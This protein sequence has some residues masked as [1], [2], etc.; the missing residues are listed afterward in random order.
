MT[1][2]CLLIVCLGWFGV[3]QAQ[4]SNDPEL[5]VRNRGSMFGYIKTY[6]PD[7]EL[8]GDYLYFKELQPVTLHL[9]DGNGT[10]QI[11]KA[12]LDLYNK[13]LLVDIKDNMY[14]VSYTKIDSAVFE[15]VNVTDYQSLSSNV[16]ESVLAIVLSKGKGTTLYK[17]IDIQVIKPTYNEALDTGNRNYVLR[18]KIKYFIDFG[19]LGILDASKKTKAFKGMPMY[20]NVRKFT[21]QNAINFE[22]DQ[23]MIRL[24]RYIET[25][26]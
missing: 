22:S 11:E 9:K 6:Q 3:S 13:A 23:D 12:N 7:P 5:L 18:K 17:T 15:G 25:L 19:E 21:K 16:S 24:H 2:Y 20:D 14:A 10:F 4:V 8:E 1:K 26:N